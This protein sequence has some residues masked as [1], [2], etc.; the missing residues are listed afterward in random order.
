M[1]EDTMSGTETRTAEADQKRALI[2]NQAARLFDE[3]GYS[4]TNMT[5]IARAGGIAKPTLYHYFRSRGEILVSIHEE[6]VTILL[7]KHEA[8][9]D[10]DL[11]ARDELVELMA[12]VVTLLDTHRGHVRVFFEHIRDLPADE[13]RNVRRKRDEI[14]ANVTETLERGIASGEFSPTL[15][16]KL[17]AWG[18]LGMVNWTYQWYRENGRY[19]SREIAERFHAMLIEGIGRSDQS[20]V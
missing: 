1:A 14:R 7:S 8:R 9:R 12:D 5:D 15:D 16:P 10:L 4:N 19:S 2:I 11:S 13:Q 6:F 20:A 3:R 18:V 17:A